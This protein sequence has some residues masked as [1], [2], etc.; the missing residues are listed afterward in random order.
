MRRSGLRILVRFSLN[1]IYLQSIENPSLIEISMTV[2]LSNVLI[3]MKLVTFRVIARINL[4]VLDVLSAKDSAIKLTLVLKK[5]VNKMGLSHFSGCNNKIKTDVEILGAKTKKLIDTG[6][7]ITMIPRHFYEK[8]GTPKLN[9]DNASLIGLDGNS[10]SPLGFF[11]SEIKIDE[12]S[13]PENIYVVEGDLCNSIIIGTDILNKLNF[14][15]TNYGFKVMGKQSQNTIRVNYTQISVPDGK[16][17]A[18]STLVRPDDA[19]KKEQTF[20]SHSTEWGEENGFQNN[21]SPGEHPPL[22]VSDT[23]DFGTN[24]KEKLTSKSDTFSMPYNESKNMQ[25]SA[26]MGRLNRFNH[27]SFT[28]D[29]DAGLTNPSE[30]ENEKTC[31]LG[32]LADATDC[33]QIDLSHIQKATTEFDETNYNL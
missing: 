9:S 19:S 28:D 29:R 23:N 24:K 20:L 8:V 17:V 13:L 18:E 15:I 31:F 16:S 25:S 21:K 5:K 33:C 26:D 6:S 27:V 11:E 14:S 4:K 22:V 10:V 12:Y 32:Q 1:R 2:K 30:V 3:V 7:E